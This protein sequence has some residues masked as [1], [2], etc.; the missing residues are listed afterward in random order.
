MK[1]RKILLISFLIPVLFIIWGYDKQILSSIPYRFIQKSFF[2]FYL[3]ISPSDSIVSDLFAALASLIL[4]IVSLVLIF[5]IKTKKWQ[6][7]LFSVL[8][9]LLTILSLSIALTRTNYY[10]VKIVN[11]HEKNII[12][13]NFDGQR[14]IKSLEPTNGKWIIYRSVYPNEQD[15]FGSTWHRID[16][17]IHNSKTSITLPTGENMRCIIIPD[18]DAL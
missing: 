13:I 15:N 11:N 16:Y 6:F 5:I 4:T 10:S 12:N 18:D 3:S 8:Y 1:I 7:G 9:F 2:Q 17:T 14:K